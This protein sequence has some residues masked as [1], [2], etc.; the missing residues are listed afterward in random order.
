MSAAAELSC[1]ME[2]NCPAGSDTAQR[3]AL[4]VN[5]MQFTGCMPA[6]G[7]QP[8]TL[9]AS[10]IGDKQAHQ[11]RVPHGSTPTCRSTTAESNSQSYASTNITCAPHAGR[12][13]CTAELQRGRAPPCSPM[14]WIRALYP[15]TTVAEQGPVAVKVCIFF[16]TR[17]DC[18]VCIQRVEHVV[19]VCVVL[20]LISYSSARSKDAQSEACRSAPG[21]GFD[22][23]QPTHV[24]CQM[25]W[26]RLPV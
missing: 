4:T 1:I 21:K 19:C 23:S 15:L 16:R 10:T 17:A 8:R 3:H 5:G 13:K 26:M 12:E 25:H 18:L 24:S 6:D 20:C 9:G 22:H 2:A 14:E 11:S 7:L